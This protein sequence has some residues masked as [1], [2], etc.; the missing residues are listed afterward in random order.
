MRITRHGRR[1]GRE[2]VPTC[3]GLTL[4]VSYRGEGDRGMVSAHLEAAADSSM[5]AAHFSR[6]GCA[7]HNG[8]CRHSST[9]SCLEWHKDRTWGRTPRRDSIPRGRTFHAYDSTGF[10]GNNSDGHWAEVCHARV[11]AGQ[12]RSTDAAAAGWCGT[13]LK[14]QARLEIRG[15]D[16]ENYGEIGSDFGDARR[17]C[18]ADCGLLF[19]F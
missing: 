7:K 9:G 19:H 16:G 1:G 15:Q 8:N 18:S 3:H 11:E 10:D 5:A 2:H 13:T 6:Q 12:G 17:S 14:S 4:R